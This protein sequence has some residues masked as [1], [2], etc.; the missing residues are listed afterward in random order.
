LWPSPHKRT[1]FIR[2]VRHPDVRKR[3]I[4]GS[5][6]NES[7]GKPESESIPV[8]ALVS[9]LQRAITSGRSSRF[10]MDSVD[11]Y[12]RDAFFTR[13]TSLYR[14]IEPLK[15]EASHEA[16]RNNLRRLSSIISELSQAMKVVQDGGYV[17]LVGRRGRVNPALVNRLLDVD[18]ELF[19]TL[20]ALDRSLLKYSKARATPRGG[21]RNFAGSIS[22][23]QELIDKR[24]RIV[25]TGP[26]F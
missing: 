1:T 25:G 5:M 9:K 13:V 17:S 19:T 20:D 16:E 14:K 18:S 10:E 21:L 15:G 8:N 6:G 23:A 11:R 26:G 24:K 4:C 7:A 2:G 3:L 12:V 22:E